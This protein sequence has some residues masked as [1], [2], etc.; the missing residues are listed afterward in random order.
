MLGSGLFEQLPHIAPAP[1]VAVGCRR[2]S[3]AEAE[4]GLKSRHRLLASIVSENELVQIHL[5]L[6]AA[7]TVIGADQPVLE[8]PDRAVRQRHDRGGTLAQGG[9][10]RLLEGDMFEACGV[11]ASE[12]PKPVGVD[13]RA[14]RDFCLRMAAI[15]V[16]VKFGRTSMRTRPERSPR[17]STATR[18]GTARRPFSC[19]LPRIPGWGPPIQVSSISTSPW[20]GS[21]AVL[22]IARRSLWSI[23]QAVS[24]RR[25]P[26]CRWSKSADT[27]R[28]SVVIRYAAQNHSVNGVLVLC[29][30]VPA[31]R[32]T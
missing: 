7:D 5:Q 10:Q 14:W 32:E 11:Q 24:Y 12:S 13:R 15:V 1:D 26:N 22:T 4:Q 8:I 29:R 17:L 19:R 9:S 2:A 28:L 3:A 23:I 30:I 18:T 16:A 6:R 25:R 20:R 21:R 27:P 31:V